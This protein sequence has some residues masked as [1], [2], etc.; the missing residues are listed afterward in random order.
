MVLKKL[1][2]LELEFRI[3]ND[4]D[5]SY[6]SGTKPSVSES[7]Q[8]ECEDEVCGLSSPIISALAFV[9]PC[10]EVKGHDGVFGRFAKEIQEF[11][12]VVF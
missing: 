11:C 7:S 10:K 5:I 6:A 9:H 4:V 1:Q 12:V 8:H 3:F 2:I